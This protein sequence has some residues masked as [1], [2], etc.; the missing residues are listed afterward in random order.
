MGDFDYFNIFSHTVVF[1]HL[2]DGVGKHIIYVLR[3]KAET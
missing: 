1:F 2:I 3:R